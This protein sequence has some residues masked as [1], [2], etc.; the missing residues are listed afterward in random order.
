MKV[1]SSELKQ[2]RFEES[3]FVSSMD[4][5]LEFFIYCV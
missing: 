3:V 4:A 5:V 1:F 2:G